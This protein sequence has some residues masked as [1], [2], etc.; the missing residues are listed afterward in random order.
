VLLRQPSPA[1]AL[2]APQATAVPPP[3]GCAPG[4]GGISGW[5]SQCACLQPGPCSWAPLLCAWGELGAG[6]RW[7]QGLKARDLPHQPSH[8]L[9][10][11]F[12]KQPPLA[13]P[14]ITF[15][16]TKSESLK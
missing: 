1:A 3:W 10:S 5:L 8:Q 4:T 14:P 16:S 7:G 2:G 12:H 15:T 9:S 11:R 13:L 6:L